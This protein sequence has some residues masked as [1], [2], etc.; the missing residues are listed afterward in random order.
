MVLP[1]IPFEAEAE[2]ANFHPD[3]ICNDDGVYKA[4]FKGKRLSILGDSI[5]TFEGVSNDGTAN[6]TIANNAVYYYENT[7]SKYGVARKDTWWQQ[8]IDTLDFELCVNN[9]WSG[10]QAM[11]VTSGDGYRA[12]QNRCKN[13]HKTAKVGDSTTTLNPDIIAV[14]LGTN[15]VKNATT[16]FATFADNRDTMLTQAGYS[17]TDIVASGV[18]Y[19]SRYIK[20]VNNMMT[21]YPNA[22]IYLFTLLPNESQNDVQK[23]YM[24]DFNQSIRDLVTYYQG[25]SKKVYLVDLYNET[26]ITSDFEILNKHLANTLH[27]NAEGMDV[28]TNC[29]LSAVVQKSGWALNPANYRTVEYDLTDVYVQGGQINIKRVSGSDEAPLSVSLVPTRAEYGMEVKVEKHHAT[30]DTWVDITSECYSDG[31][32]FLRRVSHSYD[33]IRITAKA[34]Y[35]PKNFRWETK[36]SSFVSITPDGQDYGTSGTLTQ[37]DLTMTNGSYNGTAFTDGQYKLSDTVLLRNEEPWVVEWK[38]S[39]TMKNSPFL[40]SGS[41]EAAPRNNVYIWTTS[42]H[43]NIGYRNDYRSA[44]WNYNAKLPDGF[45]MNASTFHVYRLVNR[46]DAD[47]TNMVYLYIDGTEIGALNNYY[48]DTDAQTGTLKTQNWLSGRDLEFS[49][50]GALNF[51]LND[52]GI[53]YLQVWEGGGFDTLRLQQLI[54]EYN[55]ELKTT[56]SGATNFTAYKNAVTAAQT[57][58]NSGNVHDQATIDN[59]VNTIT[60]ARN[61]LTKSATAT[62]I[63]SVELINGGYVPA[64]MPAG[65]KVITTPDVQKIQIGNTAQTLLTNTSSIQTMQIDGVDTQVKVWLVSFKR[66]KTTEVEYRIHAAKSSSAVISSKDDSDASVLFTVPHVAK[67]ITSIA[68]TKEPD[69]TVYLESETFDPTGMEVTAYYADGTSEVIT[70]YTYPTHA[71]NA[72]FTSISISYTDTSYGQNSVTVNLPIKVVSS[73]SGLRNL[74]LGTPDDRGE[75]IDVVGYYVGFADEG[76]NADKELLLKD[77]NTDDIIAVRNFPLLDPYNGLNVGDELRIRG[78]YIEDDNANTPNKKYIDC[79]HSQVISKGNPVTYQLKNTVKVSSWEEMQ[80]LFQT[81]TIQEYTY[82]EFTGRYFMNEYTGTEDTTPVYRV[83]MNE[84]ATEVAAIKPDG[85]RAVTLRSNVMERNLGANWQDLFDMTD[86]GKWRG[87]YSDAG[88]VALYTGANGSYFQLT[89]LDSSWIKVNVTGLSDI[90]ENTATTVI[91]YFVGIA[92]EGVDSDRELL[93]KDK[94]TDAIIAVRNFPEEFPYIGLNYGDELQITGTYKLD[95]TS[96]TPGKMYLDCQSFEKSSTGNTVTYDL[97]NTV[98][99]S[100][101]AEMQALFQVGAI[102]EYTYIEFTGDFYLNEYEGKDGIKNYRIHMNESATSNTAIRVDGSRY[103]C[104]R[105]NIMRRNLGAGWLEEF[106]ITTTSTGYPGSNAGNKLIALYTGASDNYFQ[107]TI[108]DPSWIG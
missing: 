30:N 104:M 103:V 5:S 60:T 89:I 23:K 88:M 33:K 36:D 41:Q 15:D 27:P 107:M 7:V 90:P 35:T 6:S 20:M 52:C 16:T 39:G 64:N 14:Y 8:A 77:K 10:S 38:A 54:D 12:W 25:Q 13:L 43:V 48:I 102:Q 74:I 45:V 9:S 19:F 94:N 75:T 67:W 106:G 18:K 28:I 3:V 21:A 17:D 99:V 98:K 86:T 55:N 65:L 76:L 66:N 26:S 22:Q 105:D 62:Q 2:P 71:L 82:I 4:S 73:V 34:T 56:M 57:Y 92:E 29:F 1:M 11:G 87:Q 85:K 84:S 53:D 37:N 80:T 78:Y 49:Y 101:W 51:Y 32:V 31:A 96:N 68:V 100:S 70:G 79:T 83:H 81:G 44:Y 108:L 63:Y 42:T 58:L 24:E 50:M 69:K 91:G 97:T 72:E 40:F 59:H 93:L 47:G 61:N 46:L 95:G